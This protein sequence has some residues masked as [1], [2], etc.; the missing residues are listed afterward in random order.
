[1][2]QNTH[3]AAEP[4]CFGSDCVQPVFYAAFVVFYVAQHFVEFVENPYRRGE[5]SLS[6]LLI[7]KVVAEIKIKGRRVRSFRYGRV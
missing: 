3:L 1:M 5:R 2:R 6:A 4:F 7:F